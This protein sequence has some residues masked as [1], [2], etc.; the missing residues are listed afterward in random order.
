[1]DA[2]F[3]HILRKIGELEPA[4]PIAGS[5]KLHEELGIDSLKLIDLI[6]A[7][8]RE[9]SVEL[10]EEG[11]ADSTTVDAVWAHVQERLAV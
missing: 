2:R 9:F 3:L 6:L 1:M 4:A 11:L 5:Q 8:E 7:I 10:S